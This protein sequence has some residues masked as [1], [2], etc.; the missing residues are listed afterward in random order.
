MYVFNLIYNLFL[1]QNRLQRQE[2]GINIGSDDE[3]F[4]VGDNGEQQP[5]VQSLGG[6]FFIS[7]VKCQGILNS[8]IYNIC[9]IAFVLL[10]VKYQDITKTIKKSKKTRG[11]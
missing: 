9:R 7:K 1:L 2:N 5:E 10:K 8:S 11:K 6:I 3:F 4:L